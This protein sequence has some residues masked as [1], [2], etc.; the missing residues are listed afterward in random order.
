ML[1]KNINHA[2]FAEIRYP[3]VLKAVFLF[4]LFLTQLSFAQTSK[5]NILVFSKTVFKVFTI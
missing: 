3:S 2:Q 1:I 5:I 4:S